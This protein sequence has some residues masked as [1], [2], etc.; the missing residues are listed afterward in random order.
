MELTAGYLSQLA[1]HLSAMSRADCWMP[2]RVTRIQSA[3][4]TPEQPRE[5]MLDGELIPGIAHIELRLIPAAI[6]C[7]VLHPP[8]RP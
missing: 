6:R 5:L 1:H 4:I 3:S 7:S 2:A 8:T